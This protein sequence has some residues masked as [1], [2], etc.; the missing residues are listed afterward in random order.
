VGKEC[1]LGVAS[2]GELLRRS[3]EAKLAQ[4]GTE[5]CVDL[6]EYTFCERKRLRQIL[7]HSRLLGALTREKKN[8]VHR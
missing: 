7:S 3:L 2:G 4:V 5:G 8:D 1:R 6:S